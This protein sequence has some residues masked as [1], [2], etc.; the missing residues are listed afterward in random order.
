MFA[1]SD[2]KTQIKGQKKARN[3]LVTI[4]AKENHKILKRFE[5]EK[6]LICMNIKS[7]HLANI[8]TV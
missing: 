3:C 7:H 5:K 2:K 8:I 4:T 1:K 6:R